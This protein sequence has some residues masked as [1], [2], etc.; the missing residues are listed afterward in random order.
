MTLNHFLGIAIGLCTFLTIGI[1]HPIVI[2]SHYYFGLGCRWWFLVA[3]ILFGAASVM[4]SNL[5]WSIILGVI[6]FSSL[7]SIHEITEQ[8][9]RVERGWFPANPRRARKQKVSEDC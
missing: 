2:K 6:A 5:F 9:R 1:F 3:A 7:W 8:E 4:T